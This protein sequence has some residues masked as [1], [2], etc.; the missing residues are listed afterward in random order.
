VGSVGDLEQSWVSV[1][2]GLT[3]GLLPWPLGESQKGVG[4]PIWT[5]WAWSS[6][7]P[8]PQCQ[9][10]NCHNI[11]MMCVTHYPT[12]RMSK[13]RLRLYEVTYP[14]SSRPESDLNLVLADP[15]VFFPHRS[16]SCCGTYSGQA[17]SDTQ[18]PGQSCGGE[19]SWLFKFSFLRFC[20][21]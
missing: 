4:T 13:L 21:F 1:P 5:A 14:P 6:F 15:P 3:S 19:A 12:L 16:K 8:L 9:G 18:G 10:C 17:G 20:E 2:L 7:P 11:P